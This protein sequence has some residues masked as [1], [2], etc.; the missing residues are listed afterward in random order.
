MNVSLFCLQCSLYDLDVSLSE[1]EP[2]N[3]ADP[4]RSGLYQ[5]LEEQY[6]LVPQAHPQ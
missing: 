5:Q 3:P 1:P 4:H 6:F 2:L